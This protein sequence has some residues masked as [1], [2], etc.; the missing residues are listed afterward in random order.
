[1]FRVSDK[2]FFLET[3][4]AYREIES[5][6]LLCENFYSRKDLK[7]HVDDKGKVKIYGFSAKKLASREKNC[8]FS[9]VHKKEVSKC[10][11]C[12]CNE[13]KKLIEYFRVI[14]RNVHL[15]SV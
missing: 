6:F 12:E 3:L 10:S 1:M 11:F 4:K 2:Q 9:R 14:D 5:H 8:Y 15:N 13:N 7:G